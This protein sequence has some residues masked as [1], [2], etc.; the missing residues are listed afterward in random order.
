MIFGNPFK[1]AVQ[2]DLVHAWSTSTY[3][4]GSFSI[5][6]NGLRLGDEF[7]SNEV[8]SVQTN[9]LYFSIRNRTA[10]H[11]PSIFQELDDLSLLAEL[12]YF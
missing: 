9:S 1:F 7:A 11:L 8:L 6:L 2:V 5:Y 3:K 4:N 10:R 12:F